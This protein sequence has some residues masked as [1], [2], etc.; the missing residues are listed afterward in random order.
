MQAVL[1]LVI[2][3]LYYLWTS[4]LDFSFEGKTFSWEENRIEQPI[5]NLL[6]KHCQ[7]HNEPEDWVFLVTSLGHITSFYTNLQNFDHVPT[8][9]SQPNISISTKLKLQN[10]DQTLL[11]NLDQDSTWYNLNQTSAAKY[12]PNFSFKISPE[13][14]VQNLD[15]NAQSLNES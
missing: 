14:Q 4:R 7:R 5:N 9:K 6:K 11:Q 8:S 2:A 1:I 12:W 3:F 10:I 15:Q 13:L